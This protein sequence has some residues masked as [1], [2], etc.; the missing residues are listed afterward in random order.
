MGPPIPAFMSS[1]FGGGLRLLGRR[2][3]GCLGAEVRGER[4]LE[5]LRQQLLDLLRLSHDDALVDD[6]EDAAD[7]RLLE[8]ARQ[9]LAVRGDLAAHAKERYEGLD[10]ALVALDRGG[11]GGERLD[12]AGPRQGGLAGDVVKEGGEAG[13]NPARPRIDLAGGVDDA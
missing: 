13:V 10:R 5:Q 6:P 4:E 7:D 9:F 11:A 12:D 8:G 3:L 2:P 1:A